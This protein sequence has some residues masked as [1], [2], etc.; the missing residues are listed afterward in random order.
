MRLDRAAISGIFYRDLFPVKTVWLRT[1][2]D[3]KDRKR[4]GGGKKKNP[5][6]LFSTSIA[7][8]LASFLYTLTCTRARGAQTIDRVP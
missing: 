6:S 5:H 7:A 4:K 2:W 1:S 3:G 8:P